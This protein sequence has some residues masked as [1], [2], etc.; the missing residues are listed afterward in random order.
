MRDTELGTWSL[1]IRGDRYTTIY[2]TIS[3]YRWCGGKS[4]V[5]NTDISG[6]PSQLYNLL[7]EWGWPS[8]LTSSCLNHLIC[9]KDKHY[10]PCKVVGRIKLDKLC[11]SHIQSL[12]HRMYSI[13]NY[14]YK[15]QTRS[16]SKALQESSW[17]NKICL[18]KTGKHSQEEM[19]SELGPKINHKCDRQKVGGRKRSCS[20]KI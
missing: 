10:L 17:R 8:C 5:W 13:N 9:K 14:E 6:F 20:L 1:R 7:S 16:T 4:Q 18:R 19:K 11:K 15:H 12:A 2:N 3:E